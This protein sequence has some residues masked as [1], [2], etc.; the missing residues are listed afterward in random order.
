MC[1]N[2]HTLLL[3]FQE[4]VNKKFSTLCQ[5]EHFVL[6]ELKC[7]MEHH[8]EIQSNQIL[9]HLIGQSLHRD[10]QLLQ[11]K[12]LPLPLELW[13]QLKFLQML[14]QAM[15]EQEDHS[16]KHLL[17]ALQQEQTRIYLQ[18]LWK[19][20]QVLLSLEEVLCFQKV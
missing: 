6:L 1:K 4:L 16:Q 19:L 15:N 5:L 8:L 12:L 18:R 13:F 11:I 14:Q 2:L 20:W 7:E 10:R 3:D 17:L 9:L